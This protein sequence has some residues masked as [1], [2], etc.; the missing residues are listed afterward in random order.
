MLLPK[1]W[2]WLRSVMLAENVSRCGM[3]ARERTLLYCT[4]VQTGLRSSELRSLT[5]GRL[6]L[7]AERPYVIC[8]AGSTKNKR[9]CRQYI[10]SDLAGELRAHLTTKMPTTQLFSMPSKHDVAGM[11]RSDLNAAR[12]AW[13]KNAGHDPEERL[14]REQSDFLAVANHEGETLDFHSLRH[15]CG[16]WLAMTGAH[17]KAIQTV[18]RHSTITLT[19]DTYGHL[20]PGQEAETVA[21]LPEMF[22]DTPQANQATGT[23]DIAAANQSDCG[24]HFG[25]QLDG[26]RLLDM[27]TGG[28]SNPLTVTGPGA[29]PSAPQVPMLARNKKSRRVMATAGFKAEGKGVEPST[30]YPAPDFESGC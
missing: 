13:L 30:G 20:F 11:L 29:D 4:A 6:C 28:E 18:M 10:N 16:A 26:W 9:D 1:E 8:A 17:P 21:R 24:Q 2:Q 12:K 5:R 25:Q 14:R 7:D 15:T 19:M 23:Y 22:F 27:A 3:E